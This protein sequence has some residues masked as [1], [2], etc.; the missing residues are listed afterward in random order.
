MHYFGSCDVS[1][2]ALNL[3]DQPLFEK[4]RLISRILGKFLINHCSNVAESGSM[5]R[6]VMVIVIIVKLV[7]TFLNGQSSPFDPPSF[8]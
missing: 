4:F 8:L 5:K 1:N 2:T 6:I 3:A 7:V